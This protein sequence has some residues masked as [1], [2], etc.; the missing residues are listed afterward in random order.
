M[1]AKASSSEKLSSGYAINRAADN[2][3]GL[4]I[5]EKMRKQIR[6]LDQGSDNIGD[7]ISLCQVADGAL[8]E[9]SELLQRVN[10]LTIQAANETN[11][12]SDRQA[13][14]DEIGQILLEIDRVGE[15]TKFNEIKVFDL[16]SATVHVQG[17]GDLVKSASDQGTLSEAVQIGNSY[18]PGATLDFSEINANT[19]DK[20]YGQS[21]STI[22]TYGCGE[23]FEFTFVNGTGDVIPTN[24]ST[25]GKHSYD[26]DIEGLSNGDA[27]LAKLYDVVSKHPAQT[28][29]PSTISNAAKISHGGYMAVNGAKLMLFAQDGYPTPE[30]AVNQTKGY[31][32]SRGGLNIASIRNY[33]YDY[34]AD[35]YIQDPTRIQSGS[36]TEDGILIKREPM[37]T[38]FLGI[39]DY[40]VTH[41]NNDEGGFKMM[42]MKE[43]LDNAFS[44]ISRMRSQ[45]GAYQNRLEHAIMIDDNC[46]ENTTAAESRIRDTNMADEMVRYSMQNILAQAGEAM[47][48][49][50]NMSAESVMAL[51]R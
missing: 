4:T 34:D 36:E 51:L 42:S 33:S 47:I 13:I 44:T 10:E 37:N 49:Q 16:E 21:F 14:Q 19:V 26:I 1:K 8:A 40:D 32:T 46:A 7:G 22:C 31:T 45:Y 11:S 38:K 20:L 50:A 29:S 24:L 17:T 48:S 39:K 43:N 6:G 28:G 35:V 9:V 12:P 41:L 25:Q 18:Y 2:A 3:A 27:I 5:S 30:Q 23:S 15:T